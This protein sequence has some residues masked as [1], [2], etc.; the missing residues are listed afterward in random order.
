[1]NILITICARGG[2]KGIPGKN[3]KL[4]NGIPLI[5]Y[6][7]NIAKEFS[8]FYNSNISISTD[9]LEIKKVVSE[10]LVT[11]DYIRPD[12]LATD[13]AGKLDTIK[14]LL[15]FEE[16]RNQINYDYILDL[17]VTSPLRTIIDLSNALEIL[18]NDD[19]ALNLLSVNHS[20]R[21]PYFNMVE[22]NNRGYFSLVKSSNAILSRQNAP[23]VYDLNASFYFYKRIYFEK[24]YKTVFSDSTLIY[25]MP[26]L[27]F[28]LDHKIDFDFLEY[29][30][31]ENKLDFKIW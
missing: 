23:M 9:S 25:V 26:H 10:Y 29:L 4:L 15:N 22:Q 31:T 5:A 19:M 28:D 2:S 11:N 3:I 16:K 24:E 12:Y 6:T 20:A 13:N 18:I 8:K 7:I 14:D 30:L 21:N 17:D 1:M 27:C